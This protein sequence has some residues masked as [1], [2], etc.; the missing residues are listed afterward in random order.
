MAK[1]IINISVGDFNGISPQMILQN[2][3]QIAKICQ[4]V[5][6]CPPKMMEQACRLLRVS[7][8]KRLE[9]I[10]TEFS[11]QI[12][13]GKIKAESGLFSFQSFLSAF[14][15]SLK[16][17]D[18]PLVTLPIHKKAWQ[19][20]GVPFVGHTDFFR[21]TMKKDVL[22]MM[23]WDG[24]FV[25]LYTDHIP[26]NQVPKKM[27][28]E[29]LVPF[30]QQFYALVAPEK[31]GVLG[32]NPHA[33][34]EGLMGKE[35]EQIQQAVEQLNSEIGKKIFTGPWGAD[36]YFIKNN[37][38]FA[39]YTVAMYHDQG[40]IPVKALGF[41]KSIQISLHLP[42][43][44]TSPDHGPALGLA[45]QNLPLQTQSYAHAVLYC[46]KEQKEG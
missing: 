1:K 21:K 37:H 43:V 13:P 8:P 9:F 39:S 40:L 46:V 16:N 6:H 22:M 31:V 33:G 25:V 10:K 12:E 42:F 35:E 17:P 18:Q 23:G 41:E 29:L 32:L 34:E 24:F 28:R 36:S 26:L 27:Q 15:S 14:S 4:P 38:H 45:Y 44:R 2:H 20:G 5:Y 3:E 30:F 11:F 7:V 19:M